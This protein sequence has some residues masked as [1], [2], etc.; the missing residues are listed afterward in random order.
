MSEEKLRELFEEIHEKVYS[1]ENRRKIIATINAD[2]DLNPETSLGDH[3][4]S[5]HLVNDKLEKE[6][7]FQILLRLVKDLNL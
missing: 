2:N 6:F 4:V 5:Y 3:F 1:P 7:L